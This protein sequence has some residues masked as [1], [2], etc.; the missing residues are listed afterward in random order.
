MSEKIHSIDGVNYSL[1]FLLESRSFIHDS[2]KLS[3]TALVNI[4]VD[5]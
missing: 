1:D 2:S 4:V 3:L 5:K